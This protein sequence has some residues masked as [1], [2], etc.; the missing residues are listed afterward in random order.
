MQY[1]FKEVENNKI[2]RQWYDNIVSQSDIIKYFKN[3]R[4]NNTHEKKVE[5]KKGIDIQLT[6]N[7]SDAKA[8]AVF[9]YFFN[10][11]IKGED[12]LELCD[13]Y[14]K[15][16]TEIK[17]EYKTKIIKII[18]NGHGTSKNYISHQNR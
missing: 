8:I 7:N 13:K 5:T 4:D 14:L 6:N 16:L 2:S 12:V 15:E 17:N 1:I 11:W 10:D 9:C 18:D 3:K